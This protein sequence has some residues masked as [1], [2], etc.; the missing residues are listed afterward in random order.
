[1]QPLFIALGEYGRPL[2]LSEIDGTSETAEVL[3]PSEDMALKAMTALTGKSLRAGGPP[4]EFLE[5]LQ[6]SHEEPSSSSSKLNPPNNALRVTG[7]GRRT[8]STA[9][10]TFFKGAIGA[11]NTGLSTLSFASA[12]CSSTTPDCL[13]PLAMHWSGASLGYGWL[14]FTSVYS[15]QAAKKMYQGKIYPDSGNPIA[16]E[17]MLRRPEQNT[18]LEIAERQG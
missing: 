12:Y 18:Y 7:L 11:N 5:R 4:I 14:F 8:T 17:Y 9:F 1:M 6:W 16:L 2:K 3:F 15:A 13:S 10:K